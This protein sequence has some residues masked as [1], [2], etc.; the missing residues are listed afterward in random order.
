[1][2]T[3]QVS[4]KAKL[5]G[6]DIENTQTFNYDEPD[7]FAEAIEMDGEKEAFKT[8]LNERKT[9]FQDKMRKKMEEAMGKKIAALIKNDAAI[10]EAL[11]IQI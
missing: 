4:V 9:N 8:F 7:D 5:K 3:I 2:R 11:N 6:T 10:K 1:M